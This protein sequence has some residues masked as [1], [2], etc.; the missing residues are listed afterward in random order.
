MEF[1]DARKVLDA[2]V[3]NRIGRHLS[4]PEQTVFT[5]AWQGKTYEEMAKYSRFSENYLKRDIG[6]KLWRLLSEVLGEEVSKTNFQ[7]ALERQWRSQQAPV[8]SQIAQQQIQSQ[9]PSN[10]VWSLLS[11]PYQ[12]PPGQA[13][14][15][16]SSMAQLRQ[17]Q[18]FDPPPIARSE[19]ARP[20]NVD[21]G[22][23]IDVSVFFGRA[24]ELE[25]LK[26]WILLDH[27]RLIG[28][29]G[30]GGVGKTA[31]ATKLAKQIQPEFEYVIWRSLRNPPPLSDL[32][33]DWF[34]S[35]GAGTE[36]KA[37]LPQ[38]LE[39]L[40]QHRCLLILDHAEAILSGGEL[41][42]QYGAGYEPYGELLQQLGAVNHRS[43]LV[44]TSREK[45]KELASLEG[46]TLPVRTLPLKGLSVAEGQQLLQAKG[47]AGSQRQ[48]P[49]LINRYTGNPLALKIVATTIHDLFGSSVTQFLRQIEQDSTAFGDIRTLLDQQFSRLSVL[50]TEVMYWLA[51]N[52]E[53]I[54]LAELRSDI[55]SLV[56]FSASL[57][58][59]ESL[60]RRSLIEKSEEPAGLFTLQPVVMEYITHRFLAQVCEEVAT[61][62]LTLFNSHALMKATA[63]DYIRDAQVRLI[64]R[65]IL[66][67]LR[68]RLGNDR[69]IEAQLT[70]L[71]D[72]LRA[73]AP[74]KPSY[75]A[76][77]ILNLLAQLQPNLSGY[78]FSRLAIWQA[79]LQGVNL[80]D[81]NFAQA[82]LTKSAFTE[83]F[84]NVLSVAFSPNGEFLAVGDADGTVSLWQLADQQKLFTH[85]GHVGWVRSLA[86]SPDSQWLA[87]GSEDQRIILWDLANGCAFKVLEGHGDWV[88]S[89]AFSPNGKF[90]A[91][92]SS[93]RT[94]KLWDIET[95]HCQRTLTGH[96]NWVR[97]LA[98]HPDG[99]TLISGSSDQTIKVWQVAT[100]ECLHTFKGHHGRVL[101]LA[102]SPDG[103]TLASGGDDRII[104]LWQLS[105]GTVQTT[106]PGKHRVWTVAFSP[107]SNLLASGGDAHE[108]EVWDVVTGGSRAT[109]RGHDD[110]VRSVAFSPDGHTLASGSDDQTVKLW[111]I[112]MGCRTTLK[113]HMNWVQA[114]AFSPDGQT[115]A[116]G[117]SDQIVKV[118]Q[119][120]NGACLKTLKGHS[121]RIFA[122]A[123]SPDGTMLASG[124]NETV[125]LWNVA[126]G[127]CCNTL[128]GHRDWVRTV[129]FSPNEPLL[130]SGSEDHTI[131]L[132]EIQTGQC[133]VIFSGHRS[134]V[135]SVAFSP[136]GEILASGSE[137]RTIKLWHVATGVCLQ[138]LEA[139]TSRVLSVAF[140]PDGSLLASGSDDQTI[141]LWQLKTG[142]VQATL[143]GHTDCVWS[144]AFS[145]D[146]N[147][148]VS[149]SDDQ[150]VRLW[151]ID[152]AN[153]DSS[154]SAQQQMILRGHSDR[155]R[156]VAFHPAGT[157]LASASEDETIRLWN[158]ST[159]ECLNVLKTKKPYEGLNIAGVTGLTDAQKL[160]LK[161]LGAID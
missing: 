66:E 69:A 24:E 36:T 97:S 10:Q 11:S 145:P 149:G 82:D 37:E 34:H 108:I 2:V 21:W 101:C 110:R 13:S 84:G 103:T 125:R 144:V 94:I 122:V 100:G 114:I 102:I 115:L 62:Q 23:A 127:Q 88:W 58:V 59:L 89:V 31:L 33:A 14:P 83:T 98:F 67:Q 134:W 81:V 137:D 50:E 138:T 19:S 121:S 119:V 47:F 27:C 68:L 151:P 143:E 63:K 105:T 25:K 57:E 40:K 152:L 111:D 20:A 52:C 90:L 155:I 75:A 118:W 29:L 124:D 35:L 65:P 159:R 71:T 136:N 28:V 128:R 93:D 142:T 91:S 129:A 7:T 154:N 18:P 46:K 17:S 85:K 43:C 133:R 78:D 157:M 146:G 48:W 3:F 130:A 126:T 132:W 95:G 76:G 53:P 139:H 106:L 96:T 15:Q 158:A 54:S 32:L 77:N 80:H 131:R 141:K 64:V 51:I 12:V 70:Q 30:I 22:E 112:D 5:G 99:A 148:L 44:L 39:F 107:N 135:Q 6:P 55:V 120:S 61:G 140:S 8:L 41:A 56:S 87:S 113:G 153:I 150:T 123:F 104:Q 147:R 92:S 60:S 73:I 38:L 16:E 117:G 160:T 156:S 9:G 26:N 49:T 109:L 161:A 4:D 1:E 42:G 116:S 72:Q 74:F 79:Y 45:P 86:F